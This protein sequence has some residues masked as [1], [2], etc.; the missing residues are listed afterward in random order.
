VRAR[1]GARA[2]LAAAAGVLTVTVLASCAAVPDS[3]PVVAGGEVQAAPPAA[4]RS[5]PEPPQPGDGPE[6]IVEGFLLATDA[7]VD[8][9]VARQY[10]LPEAR[11]TWDPGTRIV[12]SPASQQIEAVGDGVVTVTVAAEADITEDGRYTPRADAEDARV[13]ELTFLLERDEAGEWRIADPQ[14]E[15]LVSRTTAEFSLRPYPVYFPARE[16]GGDGSVALVPDI[17]WLPARS[18]SATQVVEVLLA[19]PSAPLY[20]SVVLVEPGRGL[21]DRGV[22]VVDGVA[23][24]DFTGTYLD[25]GFATSAAGRLFA[26]QI[27]QSLQ[28]LPGIRDV[29]VT[30]EGREVEVSGPPG[31]ERVSRAASRPYVLVKASGEGGAVADDGPP[32]AGSADADGPQVQEP[33]E[34][35]G[36]AGSGTAY[37]FV[38]QV[39]QG[40]SGPD[41]SPGLRR[42]AERV[43]RGLA[44]SVDGRVFAGVVADGAT[45]VRQS[46]DEAPQDIATGGTDLTTPSFDPQGWLWTSSRTAPA[47]LAGAPAEGVTVLAVS[48][49]GDE[50]SPVSVRWATE[51]PVRLVA[52]RLSRDGARALVVAEYPGGRVSVEVRGVVRGP[53]GRPVSLSTTAFPVLRQIL[54]AV[55]ATWL[56]EQTVAVLGS[57]SDDG[58]TAIQTSLVAGTSDRIDAP[59]GALTVSAGPG[60]QSLAVGTEEAVFLRLGTTWDTPVPALSPAH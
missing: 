48:P 23:T 43:D 13:E 58:A 36:T 34:P 46:P 19:G 5:I 27:E 20:D 53:E 38:G 51:P 29:R 56:D 50:V 60:V 39:G 7:L 4:P 17:R 18:D 47:G 6:R 10:L 2:Q 35:E 59:P 14:E 25:D 44:V 21:T 16:P 32:E 3:G 12:Y 28:E 31:V 42:L 22:S 37:S 1:A 30:V 41:E 33:A 9:E 11:T 52:L 24:V 54:S 8:L 15:V 49:R 55:D 45:L 26:A 40:G 57:T